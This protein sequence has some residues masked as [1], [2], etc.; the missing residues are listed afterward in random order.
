MSPLN[1]RM[2]HK[3]PLVSYRKASLPLALLGSTLELNLVFPCQPS[4]Q[5]WQA[6]S[7]LAQT[8]LQLPLTSALT[9]A[10]VRSGG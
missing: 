9:G 8:P 4:S 6:S 5:L 2:P 10:L 3:L 1:Y 7:A